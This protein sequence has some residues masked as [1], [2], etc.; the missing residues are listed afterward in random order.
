VVDLWIRGGD[1][2]TAG[3]RARADVGVSDGR[4]VQIGGEIPHDSSTRVIDAAGKLVIPGGIDM[5]VHLTPAYVPAG[6]GPGGVDTGESSTDGAGAVAEAEVGWADDFTS[7]SRSA[8]V[9]GITTV[10]N[11]TFP[12]IGE[13][14]LAA[15][16]RTAAIAARDSLVDFVLH[17]ALLDP[18][19]VAEEIPRLAA[20]G[21]PCIKI[22]M[23][24]GSFDAQVRSYVDLM[25]AAGRAG[26]V[27]MLHA[28]D[29][30]VVS[31]L[32]EQMLADGRGAPLNYGESRP[33]YSEA[34]A[35]ARAASFAE[36][37]GAPVYIVHLSS[38]EAL[39]VAQKARS[40][41]VPIFVETR[42]I[43]LFFDEGHLH[44]EDGALY[45][46]NPPLRGG[47]DVEALWGGILSG[48]IHTCCTD[49]A[50]APKADKLDPTRDITTVSPGMADLETMMPLLWS[51]GVATGRISAE[52]FVEIT[53]TN[54]ARIFGIYPQKGTVAVGGDADLVV[55]DP[56]AVRTFRADEA[57]TNTD[58]SLYEGWDITGWPAVTISRGEV[59]AQD[60]RITAEPGRGRRIRTVPTRS[61]P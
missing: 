35:V 2:V 19:G 24:F 52:R 55:W 22:F 17:P 43:Y 29:A 61:L 16:E 42:P 49:H 46:G 37:T 20:A 30:C 45:I 3:S 6:V 58:F 23:M 44:R 5:H 56:D 10:G 59:V 13:G 15:V 8:A 57:Q 11:I 4:I 47:A 50:P 31:F 1:V 41:G 32:A 26:M 38:K 21:V 54:A 14:P 53:S 7:G 18:A 9:G 39:E 12:R 25:A 40:R 28:E 51:E 33:V 36:A 48:S 34:V 27:T 60:G